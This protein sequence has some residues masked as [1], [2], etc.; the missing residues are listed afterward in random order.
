MGM[1]LST[2]SEMGMS[3]LNKHQQPKHHTHV[4]QVAWGWFLV[5]LSSVDWDFQMEYPLGFQWIPLHCP[6][7]T[8]SDFNEFAY[9]F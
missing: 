1:P 4:T 6:W 8:P 3:A 7:G 9:M 5:V 2:F